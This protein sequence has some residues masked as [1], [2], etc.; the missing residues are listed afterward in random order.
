MKKNIIFFFVGIL[1]SSFFTFFINFSQTNLENFF[2]AQIIQPLNEI[3]FVKIENFKKSYPE[4]KIKSAISLRLNPKKKIKEKVLFSKNEKEILPIASLTK[5]MSATIVLEDKNYNFEKTIKISKEAG[6]QGNTPN[7][8]NLDL[9]VGK[10]IKIEKLFELMLVCS[11]NDAT[12]AL[13]ELIGVE[14]FVS[15]MNRKAKELGMDSTYF[16]NPTGL[17]SQ[18]G[19]LNY[20]TAEDLIKL[21]KYILENH[22]L[23]FETTLKEK[24]FNV[25]NGFSKVKLREEEFLIGGKTGYTEKAGGSLIFVFQNKNEDVFLNVILGAISEEERIEEMQKLIN[26]IRNF[27]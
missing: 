7:C 23:I 18:N 19:N 9:E 4:L 26:W 27:Y 2:T 20:S 22:P 15:K 6:S 5:L 25:E 10:E 14:N 11:S 16:F 24:N 21:T 13:S 12:Y 1:A 8:G 17:D 3:N